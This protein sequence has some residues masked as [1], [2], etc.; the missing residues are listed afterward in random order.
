M[1]MAK[2]I[3]VVRY[4]AEPQDLLNK[5]MKAASDD[6]PLSFI[7]NH[8]FDT[9]QLHF[10]RQLWPHPWINLGVTVSEQGEKYMQLAHP[11]F[12]QTLD[13]NKIRFVSR[14]QF[15]IMLE[16]ERQKLRTRASTGQLWKGVTLPPTAEGL[17]H[18]E[19]LKLIALTCDCSAIP[20]IEQM[21]GVDYIY[22]GVS[23]LRL[24]LLYCW[25]LVIRTKKS[26]YTAVMQFPVVPPTPWEVESDT[27][28]PINVATKAAADSGIAVVVA[29]GNF[30]PKNGTTNPWSQMPWVI[31]VG[32][33][34]EDGTKVLSS[35]SRG[36]PQDEA[37]WPTVVAPGISKLNSEVEG[38]S[39]ACGYVA[40]NVVPQ[41]IDF[42]GQE[43]TESV[44][45]VLRD[46]TKP[47]PNTAQ[48]EA[49][50]GFVNIDHSFEY[51]DRCRDDFGEFK[52]VYCDVAALGKEKSDEQLRIL[53]E[54]KRSGDSLRWISM[55]RGGID[56]DINCRR[57][58]HEV[59]FTNRFDKFKITLHTFGDKPVN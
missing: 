45:K 21:E 12:L 16:E 25:E 7:P 57:L 13:Q 51:F 32:A 39:M 10:L 24:M 3:L 34:T 49:G 43:N 44:K 11:D 50:S 59:C 30:G 41:I 33:A 1:S 53:W 35:S 14:E 48:Y 52:R 9:F 38:T 27:P 47:V 56:S 54:A 26:F 46:I 5:L 15:D 40:Y 31:S 29:A 55:V 37:S 17:V 6:A 19:H 42:L 22:R 23:A 36:N 58:S 20:Q 28:D 2:Q 18:F 4:I 8:L